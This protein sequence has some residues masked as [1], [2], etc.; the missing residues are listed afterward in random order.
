MRKREHSAVER[1]GQRDRDPCR[2]VAEDFSR[3]STRSCPIRGDRHWLIDCETRDRKNGRPGGRR[4][5]AEP[6]EYFLDKTSGWMKAV[7]RAILEF[8]R[9]RTGIVSFDRDRPA[10]SVA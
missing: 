3:V 9:Q 6:R 2:S 8:R 1:S 5:S 7:I 4:L 10:S